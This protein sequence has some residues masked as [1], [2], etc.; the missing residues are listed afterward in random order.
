MPSLLK[1]SK[2]HLFTSAATETALGELLLDSFSRMSRDSVQS[3]LGKQY[4]SP[5]IHL[6]ELQKKKQHSKQKRPMDHIAH[7]RNSFWPS[8]EQA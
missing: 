7:L 2:Y 8:I 6:S 4:I 1:V 3:Q 5:I